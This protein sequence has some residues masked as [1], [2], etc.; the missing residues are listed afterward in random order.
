MRTIDN[1]SQD[2]F[3]NGL[4]LLLGVGLIAAPWYFGFAS[5]TAAAWNAW[6]FGTT[7]AILAVLALM[8][9]YDWEVYAIAAGGLWVCLAP[10]AL[11]FQEATVATWAHVS[12]GIALIISASSEVWRLRESPSAYEV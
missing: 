2:I 12:F 1:Q 9:T 7:V 3:L 6:I 11:G 10:W 5:E 4:S 8:Q